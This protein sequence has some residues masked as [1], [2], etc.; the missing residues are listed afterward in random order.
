M[1]TCITM[2]ETQ[3]PAPTNDPVVRTTA[4]A[5][6]LLTSNGDGSSAWLAPPAGGSVTTFGRATLSGPFNPVTVNT[7]RGIVTTTAI[8]A[9]ALDSVPALFTINNDKV[10]TDSVIHISVQGTTYFT[11]FVAASISQVENG[12]FSVFVSVMKGS[13]TDQ[14]LDIHFTVQ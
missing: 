1:Y 11:G 8:T 9:T 5:I 7:D 12:W 14:V 6:Y 10:T 3:D 2:N 13:I 4:P